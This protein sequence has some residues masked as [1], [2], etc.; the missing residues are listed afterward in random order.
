MH[1]AS[2]QTL[3]VSDQRRKAL[4]SGGAVISLFVL[5]YVAWGISA[6][7]GG[8]LVARNVSV[9]GVALGGLDEDD[10]EEKAAGR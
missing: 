1:E 4:L 10:V 8:D 7:T 5:L 3:G 6:L 2:W 9:E